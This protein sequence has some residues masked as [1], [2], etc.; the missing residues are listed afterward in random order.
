[1]KQAEIQVQHNI[2]MKKLAI[3]A[4]TLIIFFHVPVPQTLA[5]HHGTQYTISGTTMG[6]YYTIKFISRKK[7]SPVLWKEKVEVCLN[8]INKTFSMYMPK[9]ELSW[10]NRRKP[11]IAFKVSPEFFRVLL[12]AESLYTMTGG[13]WDGTVKPLV[14]MWGFGTEKTK[15][16]IPDLSRVMKALSKTGFSHIS[17]PGH[18]MVVKDIDVTLD[19]GSIAKGYG[20]DAVAELFM[21]FG[22]KDILVEIGGELYGSGRNARG[23]DWMVGISRPDRKYESQN[24]Y[25]VIRLHGQAIATSGTYRNFFNKS[26]KS[27]S[28]IIDPRT[29]FPVS[30]NIVSASVIAENCTFAD[31]LAT[32][33]MVM[34][35]K[36]GIE[37]VNRLENT[38]CLIIQKKKNKFIS[39]VSKN[40]K[41]L[42][43]K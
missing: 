27:F 24:L 32:A 43:V 37:L 42:E 35:I 15:N 36:K 5:F 10:F 13:A 4:F 2:K 8:Q 41:A 40:F 25:Q 16:L 38:E 12:T 34:D 18:D 30:G 3:A 21:S 6:T 9:S 28:H 33:L 7:L 11:G 39:H 23:K 26:K 14:D 22:I 19:L 31:G 20:V 1:M 29:G 17:F